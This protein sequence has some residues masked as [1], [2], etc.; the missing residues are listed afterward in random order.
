MECGRSGFRHDRKTSHATARQGP[1]ATER[2][3]VLKQTTLSRKRRINS[4]SNQDHRHKGTGFE[5]LVPSSHHSSDQELRLRQIRRNS[6]SIAPG[7]GTIPQLLMQPSAMFHPISSDESRIDIAALCRELHEVSLSDWPTSEDDL[8]AAGVVRFPSLHELVEA[9]R[10]RPAQAPY[11]L[12]PTDPL[13][14]DAA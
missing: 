5:P 14:G 12:W 9:S 2:F 6:R 3:Q 11:G 7:V 13:G 4:G 1:S 8:Q 10:G